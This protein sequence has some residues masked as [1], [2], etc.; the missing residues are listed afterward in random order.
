MP[1]RRADMQH[2]LCYKY[3]RADRVQIDKRGVR[4]FL[5]GDI[6]MRK[7][8]NWRH[9]EEHPKPWGHH[10]VGADALR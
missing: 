3:P 2:Q 9:A 5:C 8:R 6:Q 4:C 1:E 10:P 7:R